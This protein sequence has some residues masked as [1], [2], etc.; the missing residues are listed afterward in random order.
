ML[1][2]ARPA[3]LAR[4]LKTTMAA[5]TS[6]PAQTAN[7]AQDGARPSGG[8]PA[9]AERDQEIAVIFSE[10]RRAS[11]M[12]VEDLAA[13]LKTSAQTINAL[14][15]GAI[16]ALPDW[17][18]TSRIVT[19]YIGMLELDA[20]PVLLRLQSKLA[21]ATP[22]QAAG[23]PAPP[24]PAAAPA[25]A[26]AAQGQPTPPRAGPPPVP[27]DRQP[28]ADMPSAAPPPTPPAA[29]PPVP[30]PT[31]MPP[32]AER[33][34]ATMDAEMPAGPPRADAEPAGKPARKKQAGRRRFFSVGTL[35]TWLLVLVLFG[36]MAVG[37]RYAVQ[38]PK[39]VWSTVDSLPDPGPRLVR[40]I[41]ELVRPLDDTATGSLRSDPKS[42]KTDRLPSTPQSN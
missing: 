35:T 5:D 9:R 24:V 41:W 1:A 28:G 15:A 12:S 17:T 31:P 13:R 37:V 33:R 22:P 36:G 19:E 20:R 3:A 2:E 4:D 32:S 29:M 27:A 10:M 39:L 7:V 11:E 42:Q 30:R 16:K 8:D 14:E 23:T 38:N 21:A 34:D 26:P 18:E 40:S 25:P 6:A